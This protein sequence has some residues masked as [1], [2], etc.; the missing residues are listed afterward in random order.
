MDTL[1]GFIRVL[2]IGLTDAMLHNKR[3]E[4]SKVNILNLIVGIN[5]FFLYKPQLEFK[6]FRNSANNLYFSGD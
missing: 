1:F 5:F 2:L 3:N 6:L 4:Q